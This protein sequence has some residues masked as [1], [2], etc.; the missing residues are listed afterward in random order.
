[1]NAESPREAALSGLSYP[2]MYQ[3]V[4]EENSTFFEENFSN[5]S[6]TLYPEPDLDPSNTDIIGAMNALYQER[7]NHSE[8][9]IFLKYLDE[10]KKLIITLQ[11]K[12]LVLIM[13]STDLKQFFERNVG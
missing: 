5:S 4:R 2:S 7:R 1:M 12:D 10:H 11:T 9:C 8:S 6:T 13:F 3:K